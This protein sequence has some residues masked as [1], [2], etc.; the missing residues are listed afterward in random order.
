MSEKEVIKPSTTRRAMEGNDER[1]GNKSRSRVDKEKK[2]EWKEKRDWG[3]LPRRGV[4]G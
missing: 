4:G 2:K 1:M 3:D